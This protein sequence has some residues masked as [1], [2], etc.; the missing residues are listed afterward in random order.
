MKGFTERWAAKKGKDR[1]PLPTMLIRYKLM[2]EKC[3]TKDPLLHNFVAK[4]D[5]KEKCYACPETEG[6]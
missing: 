4:D 5:S 3:C 2:P 6:T 1:T